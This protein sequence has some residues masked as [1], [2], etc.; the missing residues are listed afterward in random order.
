M[1]E[2]RAVLER[3]D[4]I[5]ALERDLAGEL[6]QL[7]REAALWAEC[8]DDPRARAAAAALA[9]RAASTR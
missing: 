4:R 7:A 1:D 9:D 3:L 8:E 5:E 2:A 6:D